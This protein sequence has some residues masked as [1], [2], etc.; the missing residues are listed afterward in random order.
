M[1]AGVHGLGF[2]NQTFIYLFIFTHHFQLLCAHTLSVQILRNVLEKDQAP[3]LDS[4]RIVGRGASGL[5]QPVTPVV[6][7]QKLFSEH[8]FASIIHP[9]NMCGIST[10]RLTSSGGH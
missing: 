3:C 9:S 2:I 7:A 1:T 4:P 5:Y 10:C 8:F 6:S